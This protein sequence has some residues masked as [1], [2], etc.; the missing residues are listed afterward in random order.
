MY[1]KLPVCW[2]NNEIVAKIVWLTAVCIL[3]RWRWPCT[4]GCRSECLEDPLNQN[5]KITRHAKVLDKPLLGLSIPRQLPWYAL[6]YQP[7]IQAPGIYHIIITPP[8]TKPFSCLQPADISLPRHYQGYLWKLIQVVSSRADHHLQF[9][10]GDQIAFPNRR[11]WSAHQTDGR[12]S[13]AA[14][15]TTRDLLRIRTVYGSAR[16]GKLLMTS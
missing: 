9:C 14:K 11:S 1:T 8:N 15:I 5:S 7:H 4:G 16:W 13:L 6:V 12:S 3:D 10:S 2:N